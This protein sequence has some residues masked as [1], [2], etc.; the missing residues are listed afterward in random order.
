MN[1]DK[2]RKQILNI[3]KQEKS[4]LVEINSGGFETTWL[5]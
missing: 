5:N 2:L 3:I 1:D 4:K